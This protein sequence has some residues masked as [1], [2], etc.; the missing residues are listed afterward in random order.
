MILG[1]IFLRVAQSVY[2]R[3]IHSTLKD[4]D[5]GPTL[6]WMF[7][8]TFFPQWAGVHVALA[9]VPSCYIHYVVSLTLVLLSLLVR[10]S[11][12]K[13]YQLYMLFPTNHLLACGSRCEH[14]NFPTF[15]SFSTPATPLTYAVIFV[16]WLD[17]NCQS[18]NKTNQNEYE[19]KKEG[20]FLTYWRHKGCPLLLFEFACVMTIQDNIIWKSSRCLEFH[21]NRVIRKIRKSQHQNPQF[22]HTHGEIIKKNLQK[23]F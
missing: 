20:S 14:Q 8:W 6:T 15:S 23:S 13:T 18:Q 12:V 22:G 21:F 4:L 11:K 17:H 9:H 19:P 10:P 16:C 7:F 2:R 5:I 1:P 3:K